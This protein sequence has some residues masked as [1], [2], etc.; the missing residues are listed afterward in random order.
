[1]PDRG[2]IF[3]AATLKIIMTN[4]S[5]Q[6]SSTIFKNSLVTLKHSLVGNG[7]TPAGNALALGSYFFVIL[8]IFY[9]LATLLLNSVGISTRSFQPSLQ[10]YITGLSTAGNLSALVNTL[11]IG[12]FSTLFATLFGT[13]LAWIV[14][15]TDF[16][17]KKF[18]KINTFLTLCIPSYVYAIAWIDIFRRGGKLDRMTSSIWED[19]NYQF[20]TYSLEAVIVIIS[21]NL[22]PIVFMAVSHALKNSSRSLEDAAILSG[23]SRL[24]TTLTISL[25]LIAPTLFS[26]G[27]FVFSR[28]ISNF[29]VPA[30]I[31][32]PSGT[33]VLTTRILSALN[34]LDLSLASTISVFLL[35][36]SLL[37][38]YLHNYILKNKKFTTISSGSSTAPIIKITSN[39]MLLTVSV[40]L[41]H[42]IT[43]ILPLIALLV[44]SLAKRTSL[45]FNFDNITLINYLSLSE[46]PLAVRAFYNSISYGIVAGISAIIISLGIIF[47][48]YKTKIIGHKTIE[49]IASLPMAT[50]GIVLG[51][52]AI[53]TWAD[54]SLMLYG[55]PWLIIMTYIASF[56]PV[57]LKNLTGIVQNQDISLDYAAR[58]SGA[59]PIRTFKDISLPTMTPGIQAAMLL[60][61]IIA[62]REIPISLLLFAPGNETI[63]VL[64]FTARDDFGG[65]EMAAAISIIVVILTVLAR[66]AIKNL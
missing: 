48:S 9:P 36:T 63:G 28:A 58:I 40:F 59:S 2:G 47:V 46:I 10:A 30:F 43:T 35:L 64:M 44:T 25:P 12:I 14:V 6:S 8:L 61:F 50:P 22:Y 39:K 24:R 26:I 1:M 21:I 5:R 27:L 65:A 56:I 54:S 19:L 11:Y 29:S 13:T 31:A 17:Y 53:L 41:F 16:K 32:F 62:L 3:K 57:A 37:I 49:A 33:E 23:A 45:P 34:N 60:S 18:I 51:I 7:S 4:T 38:F 20:D 55:T 66:I 15:R 42:L 52:A